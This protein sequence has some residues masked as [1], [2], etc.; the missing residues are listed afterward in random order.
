MLIDVD[1]DAG[2][3]GLACDIDGL[4]LGYDLLDG[5][6]GSIRMLSVEGGGCDPD[7]VS[8]LYS[9][10][11]FDNLPGDIYTRRSGRAN[12]DSLLR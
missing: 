5:E 4:G 11:Y 10:D 6:V 12:L 3:Q 7:F 8:D 1:Q 9:V 2:T